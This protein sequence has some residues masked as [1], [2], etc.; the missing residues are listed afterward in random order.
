MEICEVRYECPDDTSPVLT[1]Y[2]LNK[3]LDEIHRYI[4]EHDIENNRNSMKIV[5]EAFPYGHDDD[6]KKN[7]RE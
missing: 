1:E 2:G 5:T 6:K 7:A 3:N 4:Y